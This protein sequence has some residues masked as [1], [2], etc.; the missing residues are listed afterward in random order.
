[1][2][3]TYFHFYVYVLDKLPST[4]LKRPWGKR[5][6]KHNSLQEKKISEKERGTKWLLWFLLL[7]WF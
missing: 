2:G 6:S 4:M 3:V 7:L 1:M 5:I